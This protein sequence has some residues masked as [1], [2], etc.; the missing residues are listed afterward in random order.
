[1]DTANRPAQ[2]TNRSAA[3]PSAIATLLSRYLTGEIG[4]RVWNRIM[5]TIDFS[6]MSL[7]ERRAYVRFMN[8][9][10]DDGGLQ[11]RAVP[12]PAEMSSILQDIRF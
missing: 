10:A 9:M 6:G 1:M 5:K 8:D 7:Y 12:Q 3:A 2:S 4:E 11:L